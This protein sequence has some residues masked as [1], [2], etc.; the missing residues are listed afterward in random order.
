MT[1][2]QIR[3][4]GTRLG[5]WMFQYAAA[6]SA[7]PDDE[8]SFVIE[9]CSDWPKVEKFKVLFPDVI[10]TN[11]VPDEAG[12]RTGLYQDVKYLSPDVLDRL[13]HCPTEIAESLENKFGRLLKNDK[14]VSIHVRRG[15]YLILPHRHPFVG[16]AYLKKAVAR[17]ADMPN[18]EFIVCSDDIAWCKEFFTERRFPGLRF[19]YSENNSVIEDLFLMRSSRGG[20]VCSNSTFSWWG[21]YRSS[22][23]QPLTIFPSMW[24]GIAIQG[25][26]RGLYFDGSE[27]IN[28]GYTFGRM[29]HA[30]AMMTKNWL[31]RV[32]RKI[33]VVK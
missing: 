25:G 29:V 31:G 21:A 7:F 18:V 8:I 19:N 17:F 30:V 5:N 9:D 11:H 4:K 23:P 32:L 3:P 15:D 24:Y 6:K 1:Y 27:V 26:C 33:G 14:L 10:I 16:E 13:F 28:N 2:V 12:F 22:S 20:H